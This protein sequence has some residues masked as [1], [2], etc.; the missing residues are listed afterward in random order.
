MEE[1]SCKISK[2]HR[3]GGSLYSCLFLDKEENL[4]PSLYLLWCSSWTEPLKIQ[5]IKSISYT[6][7]QFDDG[8][9]KSGYY[10]PP[11]WMKRNVDIN[12][13]KDCRKKEGSVND[14][15]CKNSSNSQEI[16]IF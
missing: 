11:M 1:G 14:I 4:V 16:N 3:G 15:V 7:M 9:N 10:F 2:G 12:P 6:K 5:K 13:E 8:Q